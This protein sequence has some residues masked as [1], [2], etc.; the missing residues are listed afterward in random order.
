MGKAAVQEHAGMS[1]RVLLVD[2]ETLVRSGFRM[3]LEAED[4]I[5]VIG[6]AANGAEAVEAAKTLDPDVILMDVQMP[7]KNGLAATREIADFG[8]TETCRVIILTTFELDEYVYEALRSGATGF[9]L[10]RAPAAA[11][12]TGIRVVAAGEA[13]LAPSITRRLIDHFAARPAPRGE[14]LSRLGDLT[15]REREVFEL[16][17]LGLSNAEIADRLFLSE[18]TVKTHVK[19]IFDKLEVRDRTQAVILA[20]E[21]GVVRPRTD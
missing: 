19:H 13:L 4:D 1:I 15:E 2:D 12:V 11:L 20:Y 6:E 3:I 9:L 18:G 21:L 10:K 16:I 5:E 7:V 8:R 17:A 14:D